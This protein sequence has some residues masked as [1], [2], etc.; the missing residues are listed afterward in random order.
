M[1]A[2][3]VASRGLDVP[4]VAHVI[5]YD[6]PKSVEDYVHRIGR[7]GRAGKAGNATAFFT[8]TNHSLAK[9]L[10]ELMTEAK[11]DVPKWLVEY[12]E[13]PCY[14]GPSYNGRGRRGGGGFGG[15]DYRRSSDYGYG[16]ND[17][18]NGGGAYGGGGGY[19]GGGGGRGGYSGGGGGGGSGNSYRSSAP[20]PRY[21]PTYP[22]GTTDISASGWD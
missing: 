10:L 3:D 11:R 12:A 18:N 22:M 14:G 9:G 4:N 13:K 5:N 2:T 20:P 15:R 17:Y 21:Y 6:L 7:T 1:V 8:E 16:G 19:S